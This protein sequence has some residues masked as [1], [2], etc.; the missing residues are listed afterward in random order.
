[1]T[2]EHLGMVVERDGFE[3]VGGYLLTRLG[4]VPKIGETV[5]VDDFTVEVLEAERRRIRKVRMW[6]RDAAHPAAM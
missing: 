2:S 1:M 3:T 4:R 6:R 5:E